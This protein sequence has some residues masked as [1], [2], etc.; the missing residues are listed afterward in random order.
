M[1]L[2]QALR[3][4]IFFIAIVSL[5][6]MSVE[7]EKLEKLDTEFDVTNNDDGDKEEEKPS[8]DNETDIQQG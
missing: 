1:M 7:E 3:S 2:A 5:L 8:F 4:I 6:A